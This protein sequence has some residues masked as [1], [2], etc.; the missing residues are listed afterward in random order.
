MV[1]GFAPGVRQVQTTGPGV[2]KNEKAV[3]K[4]ST[5]NAKCD[6][7]LAVGPSSDGAG[8]RSY[9]DIIDFASFYGL[10]QIRAVDVQMPVD[11]ARL[12]S[13]RSCR[14]P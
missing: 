5:D 1:T 7:L 6:L 8:R 10:R 9:A 4:K 12:P 2:R 13:L 3:R 14:K 11:Q